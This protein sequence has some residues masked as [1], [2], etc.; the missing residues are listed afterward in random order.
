M[1][2]PVAS[3]IRSVARTTGVGVIVAI[4]VREVRP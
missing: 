2:A 1:Y 4:I 3:P